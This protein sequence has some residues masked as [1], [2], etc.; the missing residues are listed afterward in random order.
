MSGNSLWSQNICIRII[1][2]F[3][4]VGSS[5]PAKHRHYW[6]WGKG[7]LHFKS[8]IV[9]VVNHRDSPP[10][11]SFYLHVNGK[12]MLKGKPFKAS[13]VCSLYF[14]LFHGAVSTVHFFLCSFMLHTFLYL[15]LYDSVDSW[16]E[17]VF[18]IVF[19]FVQINFVSFKKFFHES[20]WLSSC[21]I[22][23]FG[24]FGKD[25]GLNKIFKN[26]IFL[27][28]ALK[29]KWIIFDQHIFIL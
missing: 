16:W 15:E 2:H 3:K 24:W 26:L 27:K 5:G 4:T 19:F 14:Q 9:E 21:F 17:Q 25:L 11:P 10:H 12:M 22:C 18:F 28:A 6:E 29:N 8:C 13:D 20:I 1:C 23:T 7:F